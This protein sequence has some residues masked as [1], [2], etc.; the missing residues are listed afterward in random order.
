MLVAI[1]LYLTDGVGRD[2][3][4]HRTIRHVVCDDRA[5]PNDAVTA[6]GD[7]WHD[8]GVHTDVA[9]VAD[10]DAAEAVAVRKVRVLVAQHPTA[11]VV[12]G[13]LHAR[14]DADIVP[15][16]DEVGF[17]AEVVVIENL[18]PPPMVSPR[19]LRIASFLLEGVSF[20]F[21]VK[22]KPI[23]YPFLF[24][25]PIRRAHSCRAFQRHLECT[26]HEQRTD[27]RYHGNNKVIHN[28]RPP[29]SVAHKG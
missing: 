10:G 16:S 28:S 7:P 13:Y 12:G 20:H 6:D 25:G 29:E 21:S 5:C 9:V 18:A 4:D 11:A 14:G 26:A 2:T 3:G 17:G 22:R 24:G 8:H 27:S 23:S 1:L 15:D 19:A